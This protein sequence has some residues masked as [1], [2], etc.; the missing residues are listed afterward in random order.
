M[1]QNTEFVK[2][3]FDLARSIPTEA[4]FDC[5]LYPNSFLIKDNEPKVP[6][7]LPT[8]GADAIDP[9]V[10]RFVPPLGVPIERARKTHKAI[11][12]TFYSFRNGVGW[13]AED[14]QHI[15]Y[16]NNGPRALNEYALVSQ[17]EGPPF[18]MQY[19]GLAWEL[20]RTPKHP[21]TPEEA[22]K[23]GEVVLGLTPKYTKKK[24]H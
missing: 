17:P 16:G 11:W 3:H 12:F 23:F 19:H 1:R 14:D 15:D 9:D 21:I 10:L 6:I 18:I 2:L 4:S 22:E 8:I 7:E 5:V 13:V 24:S 20:E